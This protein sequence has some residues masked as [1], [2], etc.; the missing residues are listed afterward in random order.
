MIEDML[1]RLRIL[2]KF[3][4]YLYFGPYSYTIPNHFIKNLTEIRNNVN[5]FS[6]LIN[7]SMN[8]FKKFINDW[9]NIY[10]I[11]SDDKK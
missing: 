2:G 1:L 5:Q 4:G 3:L 11:F 6:I 8:K 9:T 10:T 7:H